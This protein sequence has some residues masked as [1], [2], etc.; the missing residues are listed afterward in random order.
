[1][2]QIITKA[3]RLPDGSKVLKCKDCD[4]ICV[5]TPPESTT[6]IVC[7]YWYTTMRT[8]GLM[9]EQCQRCDD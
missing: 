8:G 5:I 4:N 2:K 6:P 1:M 7:P 3:E 9:V